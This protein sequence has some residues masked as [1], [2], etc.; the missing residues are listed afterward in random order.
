M[1]VYNVKRRW[2]AMKG[3]AEQYRIREKLP[4]DATIKIGIA[5][6]T[7][8]AALLDALCEPPA[9]SAEGVS[10]VAAVPE[11]VIDNAFVDSDLDIPKFLRD[12]WARLT[13]GKGE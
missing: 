4:P 1:I 2:F 11:R 8:L 9:C 12:S 5:D 6:R 10:Q 13:A 7:Q 3:A